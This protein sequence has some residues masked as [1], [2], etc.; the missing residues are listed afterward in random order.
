MKFIKLL[1]FIVCYIIYP[2]SF[3]FPRSRRKYV[4]GSFRSSFNDNAKYLFIHA[5]ESGDKSI[6]CIWLS[7]SPKCVRQVRSI[8]FR[9][10]CVLSPLGVWHAL[11]SKYWF[12]NS[13][14]SDIM[15]CLSGGAV[16]TNL[17][18]GVG[19]KR[20][21]F[22]VISGPMLD[23]YTKK[24]KMDVFT[25]PE[26]FRRPD[27]LLTSTPFQT[28][29][30]AKAFRVPESKCLEM[31]YPRNHILTVTDDERTRF[32]AR[33]EPEE[34]ARLIEKLKNYDKVYVYMPTWRD[35][36]RSIFTQSMDLK[37][38]NSIMAAQNALLVLKPHANVILSENIDELSNIILTGIRMDIYPLLPYMDV[39]ITDYSSILYDWL[40]MKGKDVILYLYDYDSYVK[41]R[42]FYYPYK[43]NVTGRI[44]N[45]F[46]ELCDCLESLDF[47]L[48]EAER[49]RIVDKFWGKTAG[50]D[51]SQKILD[52][53][54]TQ[55]GK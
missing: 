42:D 17:W 6:R 18:H 49:L 3:L 2:F 23:R 7:L 34:T 55:S 27:W 14:T 44:V 48:D 8:G 35:S 51:S 13:Y 33:Y 32:I 22:N 45:T 54:K 11:T 5:H 47:S 40:L 28:S 46:D 12:F 21:E 41:E 43:E 9:A 30:F 31:G 37:R 38:L 4:F 29:M 52:F 20:T 39:L 50:Y 53:I 15:F 19:L 10:Y 1:G 25:H 16:C 26:S 24:N 36:Q